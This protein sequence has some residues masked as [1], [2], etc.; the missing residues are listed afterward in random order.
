[1]SRIFCSEQLYVELYGVED[2]I[3]TYSYSKQIETGMIVLRN[4]AGGVSIPG[5]CRKSMRRGLV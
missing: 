4:C 5:E 2:A 3:G 1:M